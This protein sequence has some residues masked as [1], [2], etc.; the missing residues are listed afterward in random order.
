MLM[1]DKYSQTTLGQH[2]ISDEC[3]ECTH[4]WSFYLFL[5][6]KTQAHTHG[7]V[8]TPSP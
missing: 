4:L 5:E 1:K 8:H 6:T 3:G 7:D 2:V